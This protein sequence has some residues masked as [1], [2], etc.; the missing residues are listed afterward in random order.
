MTVR[1]LGLM[2]VYYPALLT[3][4]IPLLSSGGVYVRR[5]SDITDCSM[6]CPHTDGVLDLYRECGG[7]ETR[8]LELWCDTMWHSNRYQPRLLYNMSTGC[9]SLRDVENNDSCVYNVVYYGD[10]GRFLTTVPITV[11]DPV[12]ISTITSNSSRPGEDI[13]VSVQFYGEETVVTWEVDGGQLPDRYR[14]IDD[15][16]TVIIPRNDAGRRL[17]VRITNPVS[18]E[19]RE[20]QLEIT[21]FPVV[22]VV[23]P[24][25]VLLIVFSVIFWYMRKKKKR[26]ESRTEDLEMNSQGN[27]CLVPSP[28][29]GAAPA[30]HP[31]EITE[32]LDMHRDPMR[33]DEDQRSS[34]TEEDPE[35][36]QTPQRDK[37]DD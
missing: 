14:L 31:D 11:L 6:K 16:K 15:N 18:E 3:L 13:A 4:A 37:E 9:W 5:K 29:P 20:Y 17:R 27:Y 35:Y 21:D 19:T 24:V 25:A 8:L 23:V 1:I 2:A 12:M 36:E 32:L 26:L 34:G 7:H 30:D 10:N 22:A 33:T 28:T